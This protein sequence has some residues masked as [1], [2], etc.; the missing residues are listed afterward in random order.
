MCSRQTCVRVVPLSILAL[1]AWPRICFV[2]CHRLSTRRIHGC[3]VVR[4]CG[5][6]DVFSV[7]WRA[8][9]MRKLVKDRLRDSK[10]RQCLTAWRENISH[11]CGVATTLRARQREVKLES[12]GTA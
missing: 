5:L 4:A 2:D 8:M 1:A 12:R 10:E 3:V 6:A 7:A 11:G 9:G